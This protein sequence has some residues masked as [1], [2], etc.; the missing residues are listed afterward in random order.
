MTSWAHQGPRAA[1]KSGVEISVLLDIPMI[2]RPLLKDYGRDIGLGQQSV[3]VYSQVNVL[4]DLSQCC[5]FISLYCLL[6]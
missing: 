3:Q 5:L 6:C 2:A 1:F 4:N